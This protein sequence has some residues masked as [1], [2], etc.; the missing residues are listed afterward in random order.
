ME[1]TDPVT[2][3]EA[4]DLAQG[5]RQFWGSTSLS[6]AAGEDAVVGWGSPGDQAVDELI[7]DPDPEVHSTRRLLRTL[8]IPGNVDD[9]TALVRATLMAQRRGSGP[10]RRSEPWQDAD[11][12]N[13]ATMPSGQQVKLDLGPNQTKRLFLALIGR[14]RSAGTYDQIMAEIGATVIDGDDVSVLRGRERDIIEGLLEDGDGVWDL[15]E[16]LQPD[17]FKAVALRKQHEARET[18]LAEFAE[19]MDSGIWDEGDWEQFFK[20]NTWIFGYG[21]AYQFLSTIRNQPNYGGVGFEGT[22]AERGDFLMGT[23]A[24]AR[25]TVLVDIKKPET[26]LLARNPYRGEA[27]YRV[28][29]EVGGG[30]AQLQANCATWF[31]EGAQLARNVRQLGGMGIHTHEPKG[32]L[33]VGRTAEFAGND[34]KAGSFER[35]RRRLQNPEI[36]TFDELYERAR[37]LIQTDFEI[38]KGDIGI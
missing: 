24:E 25:F 7:S 11:H 34:D 21:L 22:G 3:D 17:M 32:I 36:L 5:D 27:I 18:A 33:V 1:D 23:E 30:V 14:Y 8:I 35:F 4:K 19:K 16:E 2:A 26:L 6:P 15:L 13:L 12:F 10:A 37:Y 20:D 38:A 29:S 9:P 31:S 28:S